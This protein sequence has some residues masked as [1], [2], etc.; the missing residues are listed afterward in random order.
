MI[1]MISRSDTQSFPRFCPTAKSATV[2]NQGAHPLRGELGTLVG[3]HQFD[4]VPERVVDVD[5]PIA[6]EGL[7]ILDHAS[8][9]SQ[10]FLQCR[11]S[12]YQQ[13]DMRFARRSKVRL[14]AQMNF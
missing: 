9:G 7:I 11:E 1:R 4:A 6:F 5:S 2:F 14:H 3:F 10:R 13:S 8:R 12:A